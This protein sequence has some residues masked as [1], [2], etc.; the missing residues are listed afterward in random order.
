M[1]FIADSEKEKV[2]TILKGLEN[3]PVVTV[4]DI[5]GFAEQGGTIEF[6]LRQGRLS[7]KINLAEARKRHLRIN[8]SLLSLATEVI[9]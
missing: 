7:F 4:S 8:A 6:V 1:L 2:R 5:P 9:R 3:T